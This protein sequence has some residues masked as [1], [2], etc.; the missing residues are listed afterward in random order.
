MRTVVVQSFRRD[1]VPEWITRCMRSVASWADARG[2]HYEFVDD[3]LFDHV[4]AAL[5]DKPRNSL[6]PL[7]DIARLGLLRDRL[8]Q[9]YERALWIDA[10][11]VVFR[12]DTLA[13]PAQCGAMLCHEIWTHRNPDGQVIHDRRVN[14]AVMIFERGHPLLDFLRYAAIELYQHMDPETMP[15]ATLGTGFLSNLGRLLPIRLFNQVACL[16]PLLVDA[17]L[18]DTNHEQL[19]AHASHYGHPFHAVNLCHSLQSSSKS[20]DSK[21]STRDASLLALVDRLIASRG[22]SLRFATE[23]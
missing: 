3:V 17:L 4:P 18:T 11:V 14:N 16:S 13:I 21:Q 23:R 15:P 5:L 10:D 8:A 9:R 6:L 1:N 7:T 12:P 2:Y 19:K 20:E 22:S